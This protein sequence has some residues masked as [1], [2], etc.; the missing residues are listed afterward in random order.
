MF[1][2]MPASFDVEQRVGTVL[3]SCGKS[4]E[5]FVGDKHDL[6]VHHKTCSSQSYLCCA[7]IANEATT[8]II[9]MEDDDH[10]GCVNEDLIRGID[11]V[12]N[13]MMESL[14]NLSAYVSGTNNDDNDDDE[15]DDDDSYLQHGGR[16]NRQDAASH[17]WTYLTGSNRPAEV[18]IAIDGVNNRLLDRAREEVPSVL[19]KLKRKIGVRRN[20]NVRTMSPGDC[21]KAFMDPNFLGCMKAFVNLNMSNSNDLVSSSDITAFIRVELVISF[22][23]LRTRDNVNVS[24]S[25]HKQFHHGLTSFFRFSCSPPSCRFL[26]PCTSIMEMYLTSHPPPLA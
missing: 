15:S 17:Q 2:G 23:K 10:N 18:F 4:T 5:K 11:N 22:C 1:T 9:T 19:L 13:S 21:L 20:C 8:R 6:D 16:N 14:F 24:T 3:Q 25:L 26:P 12:D 7:F